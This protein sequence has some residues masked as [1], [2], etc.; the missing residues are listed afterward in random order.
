[1][2]T[3]S[4]RGDISRALRKLDVT[5][6]QARKAIPRALNKTATTARAEAARE[7]RSAGYGLKIAAIKKSIRIIRATGSQ[8]RAIVRA[9]GKPIPLIEYAARQ[10]R[11]GVTV[12]VLRGR[13]LIKGVFI[14]TM[15]SGHRGV[16]RRKGLTSKRVIRKGRVAYSGLP[17]QELFGPSVPAAFANSVVQA[18]LISAIRKRFPEVLRQELRFAGLGR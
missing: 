10:T 15:P 8:L 16:V 13:K 9:S 14:A 3:V 1:V 6:E 12:N 2:I 17:I 18:A 5:R 7:I 11:A 4:V